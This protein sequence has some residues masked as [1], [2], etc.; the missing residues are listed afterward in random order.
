MRRAR[1]AVVALALAVAA[2]CGGG[3]DGDSQA[4]EGDAP[5]EGV[6]TITIGPYSHPD[7][8]ITSD[9]RPPVGGDH[10]PRLAPCDFYDEVVPD[11]LTVHTI[12]HGAVWVTY[13]P[14]L[15]GGEIDVIRQ[16]VA[17][18]D[19]VLA[20][21]YPDQTSPVVVTAWGRQLRLESAR[22][23]RLAQF[24]ERYVDADTAPE[25]GRAC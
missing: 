22:D 6:E 25:A 11:E 7:G 2:G 16:L 20:S 9:R 12:E 13:L 1:G 8:E 24:V 15:G 18:N 23:E 4:A 19:R 5:I 3:D 10:N 21:P 17:D 14:S